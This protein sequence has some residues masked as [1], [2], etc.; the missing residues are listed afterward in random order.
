MIGPGE[1]ATNTT[2]AAIKDALNRANHRQRPLGSR[3]S[4]N[5]RNKNVKRP[6]PKKADQIHIQARLHHPG[7]IRAPQILRS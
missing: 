7:V 1:N 5:R 4:G 3:P 2:A 6:T